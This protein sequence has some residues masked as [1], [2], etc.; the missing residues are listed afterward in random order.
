MDEENKNE[1][2][3]ELMRSYEL[4][5][6]DLYEIF[7]EKISEEKEFWKKLSEEE[8]KHAYWLEVLGANMRKENI[9][10]NNDNR[11]NIPLIK[12]SL[13]H[14][15]EVK[16]DF[17]NMEKIDSFDALNFAGDV[18]NSMV[19]KKFFEVFYGQSEEFDRVMKLLKEETQEHNQRIMQKLEQE[20]KI[21]FDEERGW[22]GKIK[23][24]FE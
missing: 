12:S 24:M 4:I 14:V 8:K 15:E 10:L 18:E 22:W 17:S 16:E 2:V 1:D 7:S 11:F 19:E 6:K 20:R 9:S 23:G 21:D 3:L 13:K 5:L